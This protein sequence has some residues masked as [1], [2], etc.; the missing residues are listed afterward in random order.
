[1]LL[2]VSIEVLI[3]NTNNSYFIRILSR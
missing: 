3:D 1:M 2:P